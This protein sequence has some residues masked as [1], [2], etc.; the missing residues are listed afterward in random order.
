VNAKLVTNTAPAPSTLSLNVPSSSSYS[1]VIAGN[2]ALIKNEAGLLYLSGTNAYTGNT[3]V[4][5]GTLQ[6]AWPS[7]ATVSTVRVASGALLQLDFPETNTVAGLVL[8]GLSQPPGVYNVTTSPSYISGLGSLRVAAP[9]AT[10]PTNIVAVVDG[11]NLNLSWPADHI[12]W[13]LETQT[14]ALSVGLS[15]NWSVWPGSDTTNAISVPISPA[16]PTVF[17]R[18]VYP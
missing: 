15:T 16:N 10:N 6:L 18:L 11:S 4:N 1:G 12:G 5:G 7:L 17:F 8:N 3:T 14:N 13:R 2:V 9:V